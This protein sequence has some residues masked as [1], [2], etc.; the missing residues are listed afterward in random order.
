MGYN[1]GELFVFSPSFHALLTIT[2]SIA[3]VN[4]VFLF[5]SL[6]FTY[7]YEAVVE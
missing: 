1:H 7:T 2:D 6:I 3:C 4:D 5:F